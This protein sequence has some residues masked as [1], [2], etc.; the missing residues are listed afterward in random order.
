MIIKF[1]KTKKAKVLIVIL[2]L[3]VVLLIRHFCNVNNNF[4][5]PDY[6][7]KDISQMVRREHISDD[8]YMHIF[9]QTGISPAAAK[10]LIAEGEYEVIE[11]LHELYFKKPVIKKEYIAYPVTAEE[12]NETQITPLVNLKKG[13]VLISF[14]THTLD[15]RHGHCGLVLDDKGR[16]LLE[17]MS[18]GRTSCTTSAKNWGGYPGFVVLRYPDENVAAKAADYAKEHLVDVDYSIFAGIIKKDKSDEA[19]PESSHCSHIVWQAYKAVGVDIDKNGGPIVTPCDVAMS[20]ELSV[21]QIYGVNPKN[22][23][24]RILK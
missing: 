19:K 14:N 23:T 3:V 8:D 20:K 1:L 5:T 12:R 11:D 10:E 24:T 2:V 18:I 17:H 15:W 22:F 13:D 16:I 4:Y 7:K 9:E 21:V 6:E